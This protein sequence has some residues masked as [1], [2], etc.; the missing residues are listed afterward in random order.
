M[1]RIA[2]VEDEKE[3]A[4]RISGIAA[5]FLDKK[6]EVYSVTC[7]SGPIDVLFELDEGLFFDLYLLDIVLHGMD[8]LE[9]GRRI[10]GL[11][12]HAKI[13]FVTNHSRYALPAYEL[14]PWHYLTKEDLE[15]GLDK[16]LE[17]YCAQKSAEQINVWV[18]KAGSDTVCIPEKDIY[19]IEKDEKN[20]IVTY[21]GGSGRKRWTIRQAVA[22]LDPERFVQTGR[23]T[24]INLTQIR[25]IKSREVVLNNGKSFPVSMLSRKML[26]ERMEKL[27][28]TE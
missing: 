15:T 24:V 2:I 1:I 6:K 19:S 4:Q 14:H 13:V 11:H 23:G 16:V 27:W 3:M 8:G 17:H 26:K 22:R 5:S 25:C 20:I 18:L 12:A 21:A 10:L 28:E 7:Y 9:L